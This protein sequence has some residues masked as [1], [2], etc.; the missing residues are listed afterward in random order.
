M[1]EMPIADLPLVGLVSASC[2]HKI[3]HIRRSKYPRDSSIVDIFLEQAQ[4]H[5]AIVAVTDESTQLT[6]AELDRKSN[7]L[8]GWLVSQGLPS[9]SL[10]SV[11]MPRSCQTIVAF[12]GILKAG[13][14]YLPLDVDAPADRIAAILATIPSSDILVVL[15][16]NAP[17]PEL[18]GLSHIRTISVA[19]VVQQVIDASSNA[20]S[21]IAHLSQPRIVLHT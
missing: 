15:E 20:I 16:D 19:N 12:L 6:Y 13:L 9:Q 5:S 8:A 21:A 1:P 11:F 2:Q 3:A 18:S 4:K 14:A 10:V 7:I 17:M